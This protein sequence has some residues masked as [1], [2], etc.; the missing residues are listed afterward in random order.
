M[1]DLCLFFS[2][3]FERNN[4]RIFAMAEDPVTRV[5]K[6][7]NFATGQIRDIIKLGK[8]P[9]RRRGVKKGSTANHTYSC[10]IRQ[11]GNTWDQGNPD[12][13]RGNVDSKSVPQEEVMSVSSWQGRKSA[14]HIE[15]H[16][17][18]GNTQENS[19]EY[20]LCNQDPINLTVQEEWPNYTDRFLW[21]MGTVDEN[22]KFHNYTPALNETPDT[23]GERIPFQHNSDADGFY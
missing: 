2:R 14:K 3:K 16:F 19:L 1:T 9:V 4:R 5:L 17:F 10:C 22:A 23:V 7:A 12:I 13:N 8:R 20:S 15:N 21:Y 11:E 18:E 6:F